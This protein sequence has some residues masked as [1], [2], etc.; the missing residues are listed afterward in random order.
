MGVVIIRNPVAGGARHRS[1]WP[2]VLSAFQQTFDDLVVQESRSGVDARRLAL[3]AANAGA[4]L[5]IAA[6]GDGTISDVVDGILSS[7]RPDSPLAF[8]PLGTGSDFVRNFD[9]PQDPQVLAERIAAA[10]PRQID[11][12]RLIASSADGKEVRRHFVNIASLGISGEIV[13]CVNAPGARWLSGPAR[14][15]VHSLLAILRYKPYRFEVLVDGHKVHTGSLALV[16]I[17]NGGWFGGGMHVTPAADLT[18]GLFDVAVM[19]EESVFGL[20]GLLRS[21]YSA[22]HI[23]HPQLSFHRG[24]QVECR[25]LDPARF[26]VEVDGEQP[27]TGAFVA[28]ILPGALTIKV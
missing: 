22:G 4:T 16:A 11:A 25:P 20:I 24:R 9:L 18:D 26:P 7:D 6:G 23:G 21:L 17:A 14:F 10:R 19:R 28:E 13:E 1:R 8:L 3:E 27:I 2:S 15:L 5:V 12:A